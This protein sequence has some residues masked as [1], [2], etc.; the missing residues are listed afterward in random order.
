MTVA[1]DDLLTTSQ[2][3]HRVQRTPQ[4]VKQLAL[5]GRLPFI[6]SPHGRLFDPAAVD[7]Y[8]AERRPAR[9]GADGPKA[10]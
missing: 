6:S 5:A 3:A 9:I 1:L 2:V 8:L 10:A 7:R 4:R